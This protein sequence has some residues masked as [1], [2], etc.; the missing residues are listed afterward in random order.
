MNFEIVK[1]DELSGEQSSIYS[2]YLV[3][4]DTSLFER[5][6]EENETSYSEDIVEIINVLTVISN[7]TGAKEYFF[8]PGQGKLG[9]NVCYLKY[10]GNK[11]NNLRLYCLRF[12]NVAVILGGGGFK[13]PGMKA[14]QES[15]KLKLENSLV[16][17]ISKKIHQRIL[18]KEITWSEDGIELTGELEFTDEE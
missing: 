9:D 1:L 8:K 2:V 14:F 11:R 17:E 4:E 5:F 7:D 18:S 10:S 15:Q 13:P 16:R 12:S 6:I 3:D